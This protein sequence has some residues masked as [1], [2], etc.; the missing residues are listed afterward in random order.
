MSTP[1]HKEKIWKLIKDIKTGMLTTQDKHMGIKARPMQLVQDEYSGT[2]WFFTDISTKKAQE[3]VEDQ[4]VCVTFS[5]TSDHTF[6]SLSGRA[7]LSND[8]KM[9]DKL[10]NPMVGTWFPK[11][12]DAS[13]VGL[14]EIKIEHGEHWDSNSSKLG[15][16]YEM[17]KA[18]MNDE[19]PELGEHQVF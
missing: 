10:W 13:T 16:I 8:Q 19:K 9:I 7:R 2:L 18:K 6:V 3:I 11:G 17:A 15:F 12:K 5:D 1:E 14:I 4:E